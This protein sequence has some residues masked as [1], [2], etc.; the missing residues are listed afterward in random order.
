MVWKHGSGGNCKCRLT[1][2]F[3]TIRRPYSSGGYTDK[4][5]NELRITAKQ[6]FHTSAAACKK[7]IQRENRGNNSIDLTFMHSSKGGI[8]YFLWVL[9]QHFFNKRGKTRRGTNTTV[10]SS[11]EKYW[12][13]LRNTD[14][15]LKQIFAC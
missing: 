11:A 9:Q 5:N 13:L 14:Y 2:C 3:E 1:L 10:A 6:Y 15:Y 7:I 12:S 8:F 4:I